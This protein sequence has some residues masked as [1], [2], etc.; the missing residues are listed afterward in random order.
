ME[1]SQM[2]QLVEAK[3]SDLVRLCKE[4]SVRRLELFGSGSTEAFDSEHSDL[5]FLVIFEPTTPARHADCYFGLLAALQDLF[6]REIDLVEYSAIRNPYFLD[7]VQ[8]N[9]IVL[10][11]A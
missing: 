7:S 10:Y 8:S 3:R 6:G 4:F 9:R 11:A 5:D 2:N 1:A